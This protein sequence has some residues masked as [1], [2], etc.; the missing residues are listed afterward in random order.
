MIGGLLGPGAY[1]AGLAGLVIV[2]G[3]AWISATLVIRQVLP[4]LNGS[5]RAVAVGLLT[6]SAVLISE[7]VPLSLG[8]LTRLT[9]PLTALAL[10]GTVVVTTTRAPRQAA[11]ATAPSPTESGR[12]TLTQPSSVLAAI[13]LLA[14]ATAWL[15]WLS[16][17]VKTP[18]T[19]VDALNF[20]FPGV[21]RFIQSGSLWQSTQ[22][23]PDQAQGNYP[24]FGDLLLL[25]FVLPWHSLAFVRYAELPLLA[26][27]GLG[28]YALGRELRAPAP[29][30]AIVAAA[31]L[32][33]RPT[34]GPALP[35]VLA[36]TAFF[37]AWPAGLLFLIRHDRTGSTAELVLAG[38][39]LGIA[40]GTNWYGLTDVP[41]GVL[42]WLLIRRPP[43]RELVTLAG[44]IALTGGIWLIRNLVLTGNPVFDYAVHLAGV[45]IFAAPPSA[46]RATVGFT[47]AHYL[48]DFSVVRHYIW[49]AFRG[50]FGITSAMIVIGAIGA[51]L[52][53][54]RRVLVL[55]AAGLLCAVAY[56]ITPYSALGLSGRPILIDAN[57]RYGVPALLAAAPL[58]AVALTRLGRWRPVAELVLLVALLDDLHRYLAVSTGREIATAAVLVIAAVAVEVARPSASRRW[59]TRRRTIVLVPAAVAAL[60]VA[61]IAY[62]EERALAVATYNPGDPTVAWVL[63]HAPAGTR[64]GITGAWTAQGLEP[65]APLF[66]P[67]L[68][69]TVE[70][71][72]RFEQHRLTAFTTRRR[73]VASLN[74][75]RFALL[76]IG[77]GFPPS[78]AP[79]EA[80]WALGDGY[81]FI[82]RSAR[83]VLLAAPARTN[84]H[85]TA[86]G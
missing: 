70:Y 49:P 53:R 84:V 68:D 3:C 13:A 72:G 7:L 79:R 28:V 5:A 81:R 60:V 74:R 50:D 42:A 48:T 59:A 17:T 30:A 22:Y 54:D 15:A 66:G 24:Q 57:T 65:V 38:V 25:S 40:V 43:W 80:I 11:R 46:L 58:L 14:T 35:D 55:A 47:L 29:A 39:G 69:N 61:G 71:V 51:A 6:V 23:I 44:V 1:L 9:A 77:T 2:L 8:I 64:I 78:A 62:H 21:I 73:F 36:D 76:E 18:V 67:R 19:S 27:A 16:V 33:I 37:A 34:L 10:L 56:A 26:L 86:G 45:T 83:L 41:L 82:T 31:I 20:H 12:M 52:R 85:P 4:G 32:A 75:G 63:A